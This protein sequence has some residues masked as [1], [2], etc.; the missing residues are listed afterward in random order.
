MFLSIDVQATHFSQAVVLAIQNQ[1][2]P[3]SGYNQSIT[4][5]LCCTAKGE[6]IEVQRNTFR[7]GRIDVQQNTLHDGRTKATKI[8][9]EQSQ[10]CIAVQHGFDVRHRQ[11]TQYPHRLTATLPSI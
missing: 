4:H 1:P 10:G 6:R 11:A 8:F 7:D 2:T 5:V 9:P 3:D